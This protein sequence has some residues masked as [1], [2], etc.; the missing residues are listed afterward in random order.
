[1]PRLYREQF[2]CADSTERRNPALSKERGSL[3]IA[4]NASIRVR[5]SS[6]FSRDT[7]VRKP[8]NPSLESQGTLPVRAITLT[9]NDMM[10]GLDC[11]RCC[12]VLPLYAKPL[13]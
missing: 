5:N 4:A 13:K 8:S 7:R 6:A 1:M 9:R 11:G 3:A 10:D 2:Y 12:C